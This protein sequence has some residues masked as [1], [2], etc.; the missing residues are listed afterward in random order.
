[1]RNHHRRKIK[2]M[3]FKVQKSI[4]FIPFDY[5]DPLM[6]EIFKYKYKSQANHWVNSKKSGDR[7][8]FLS[9][10]GYKIPVLENNEKNIKPYMTINRK[11]DKP[12]KVHFPS[13][14]DYNELKPHLSSL[15]QILK[16]INPGRKYLEPEQGHIRINYKNIRRGLQKVV[17]YEQN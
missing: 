4:S 8:D 6:S 2:L 15:S 10:L 11:L 9:K 16:R 1:M 5:P 7:L 12:R 13:H 14:D 17:K 3:L